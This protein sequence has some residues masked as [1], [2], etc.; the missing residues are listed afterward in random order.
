MTD[1]QHYPTRLQALIPNSVLTRLDSG[2]VAF[3]GANGITVGIELK[4]VQDALSCL[5]SSRLADTQLPAMAQQY[6]IRYLVVE[7]PY[8]AEPGTG[9]LQRWKAFPSSKETVCG[10]WYDAHAGRNRVMYSTFEMWLHTM[11]ELGGAR[12][13]RTAD[14]EGTASLI[15]ALA[16]WWSREEHKSFNV[17]S[18][19]AMTAE[20]SR[21]TMTR[22]MYA[23]LP[24][25]GW[26]RSKAVAQR[27]HTVADAVSA[28]EKEWA[29]IDGI[30]KVIAKRAVEALNGETDS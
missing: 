13:E 18:D 24:G 27:F 14:V 22:R 21:P 17:M 10:R 26:E 30:G 2:D 6:D 23:L 1:A 5:Y 4:R 16:V 28:T 11:S 9:V 29:E 25:I 8:R 20:L 3:S 7:E 19:P 15:T 12:L